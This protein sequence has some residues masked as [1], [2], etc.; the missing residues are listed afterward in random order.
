MT[1]QTFEEAIAEFI[2]VS[3]DALDQEVM[4]NLLLWRGPRDVE[5]RGKLAT[6]WAAVKGG[7]R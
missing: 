1:A 2:K 5:A 3:R 6:A 4:E 7:R